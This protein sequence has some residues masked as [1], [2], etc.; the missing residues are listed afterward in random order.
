MDNLKH[1]KVNEAKKDF[2]KETKTH[3]LFFLM[4]QTVRTLVGIKRHEKY[5]LLDFDG[6][7]C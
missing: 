6:M 4:H 7:R 3:V 1:R 2:D 5:K